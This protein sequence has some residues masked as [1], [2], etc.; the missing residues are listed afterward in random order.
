MRQLWS[1]T[2]HQD[3]PRRARRPRSRQQQIKGLPTNSR[4]QPLEQ[5]RATFYFPRFFLVKNVVYYLKPPP[6]R[7]QRTVMRRFCLDWTNCCA[8]KSIECHFAF[9]ASPA[10]DKNKMTKNKSINMHW[11]SAKETTLLFNSFERVL[12]TKH[13]L[14]EAIGTLKSN[15]IPEKCKT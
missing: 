8:S 12:S 1:A 13:F 14:L 6:C 10:A 3:H 5:V 4:A 9:A 7:T 11:N 15:W 2:R